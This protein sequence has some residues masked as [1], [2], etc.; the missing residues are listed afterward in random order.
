MKLLKE[1][2][3]NEAVHINGRTVSREAVRGIIM[4]GRKLLMVYSEKNGDYK[5]PGGG[6]EHGESHETALKREVAEEIGKQIVDIIKPFGKVIEYD[7]PLEKDFDVFKMTSYY[8][9]CQVGT[10]EGK[11]NLD[12]YEKELGF[13]PVW[14]EIDTAINNNMSLLEGHQ[15]H[16]PRW[17]K[18]ELQV[19]EQIRLAL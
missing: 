15:K 9:W 3:H 16:L 10:D 2:L 4:D 14:I 1:V 18:R 6:I 17:V 5:F 8:Y 7:L 12:Q 13:L 19:L 11:Q